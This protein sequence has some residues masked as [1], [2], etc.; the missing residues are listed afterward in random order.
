MGEGPGG[1]YVIVR[2][3][4]T[5]GYGSVFEVREPAPHRP[6]RVQ[7]CGTW[8]AT[9]STSPMGINAESSINHGH[10]RPTFDADLPARHCLIPPP[11]V[12]Q[13]HDAVSNTRVAIKKS[14]L[15]SDAND[16]NDQG[17]PVPCPLRQHARSNLLR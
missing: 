3:L 13:A 11:L 5:G 1:R 15:F 4:A 9:L 8:R 2:H 16:P 10:P 12:T 7:P 17:I 14:A 6:P